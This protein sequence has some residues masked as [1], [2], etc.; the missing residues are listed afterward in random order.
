MGFHNDALSALGVLAI[1]NVYKR[2]LDGVFLFI[3]LALLVIFK[4]VVVIGSLD[5]FL[6]VD[7]NIRFTL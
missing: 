3:I 6:L 7:F 1:A 5:L 2:L 4:D